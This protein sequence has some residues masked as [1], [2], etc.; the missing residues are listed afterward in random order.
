MLCAVSSWGQARLRTKEMYF[1]VHGGALFSTVSWTPS[2]EGTTK[3]KNATSL[4]GQGGLVFR[5]AGHRF[6]GLQVEL[7]Y[8]QKGWREVT[9][10]DDEI[11]EVHYSRYP[12]L[13]WQ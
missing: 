4:S 3:I 11:P 12:Y 7:D 9:E 2:V 1:G 8:M 5:Y 10:P 13:F 6:F